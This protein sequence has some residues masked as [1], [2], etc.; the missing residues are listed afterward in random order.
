MPYK[1]YFRNSL[2]LSVVI[3]FSCSSIQKKDTSTTNLTNLK[4]TVEEAPE[5]TA[6]FNRKSGW[7]GGDG[8]FAIPLNGKENTNAS[9]TSKNMIFFSDSMIGEIENGKPTTSKNMV[10]NTVAIIEGD[11]PKADKI[12]F[13]WDTDS[14]GEP[15]TIFNPKTPSTTSGDYY[16]LG[17]GFV[18]TGKDNTTYIFAYKM[19]NLDP[20]DDWS[21]TLTK[22]NLV[23]IPA[24]STPPFKDQRQ[25]ET[26]L[27]FHGAQPDSNG[28]FGAGIFVNTIQA[29]VKNGDGYIYVYGIRGKAKNLIASR[30]KPEDFEQFDKWT[31]WNGTEWTGDMQQV[32][33]VVDGVSDE[34]GRFLLVFQ[35]AG[36]SSTVGMRIGAGPAGPFGPVIKLY[37]CPQTKENKNYFTY[38]AKA[39]PS[40]SKPGELLISYN[41]NSFD[42]WKEIQKNPN[43]YRPRFIKLKF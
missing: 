2:V 40:L 21:F 3:S 23:A 8:I 25:I 17:D 6:L 38:N 24:G 22:T 33:N 32:A 9:D 30:V 13:Y 34:D 18:N 26:P 36:M 14:L 28:T 15:Q 7:Y 11:Q 12:K 10:H 20:K 31:F 16:W 42:Y 37:D 1:N 5:W 35:S 27:S 43:L 19:R 4:F 39:H 41:V 29:G